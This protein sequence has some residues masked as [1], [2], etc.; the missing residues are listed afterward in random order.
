MKKGFTL[1]EL[2][3]VIAVIAILSTIALIGLRAAQDAAK[4]T[5]KVASIT[6]LQNALERYYGDYG[7]YPAAGAAAPRLDNITAGAFTGYFA[8][9]LWYGS[10]S[11]NQMTG[12]AA[13]P[14]G[15][16]VSYTQTA[17]T[18]YTILFVKKSG[19]TLTYVSPK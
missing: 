14:V 6:G 19:G 9:S 13:T 2:M 15:P 7:S 4:D 1:I 8:T 18:D 17:S 5:K 16:C 11:D 10:A 3:V 12:C